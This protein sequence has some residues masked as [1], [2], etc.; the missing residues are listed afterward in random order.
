MTPDEKQRQYA[1]WIMQ[2]MDG[3]TYFISEMMETLEADGM[4]DDNGEMIYEE[5]E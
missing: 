2:L 5:E 3:D 1:G 4:I